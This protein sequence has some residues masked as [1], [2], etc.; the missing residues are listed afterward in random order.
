MTGDFSILT[1]KL[2]NEKLKLLQTIQIVDFL[3]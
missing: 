1:V 3:L 2:Q